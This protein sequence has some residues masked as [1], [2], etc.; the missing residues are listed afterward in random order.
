MDGLVCHTVMAAAPPSL[1]DLAPRRIVPPLIT[2]HLN[3]TPLGRVGQVQ[4]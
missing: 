1:L 2:R 4:A 3:P